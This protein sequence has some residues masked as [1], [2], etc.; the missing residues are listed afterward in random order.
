[1][2]KL[3]CTCG[4]TIRDNTNGLS[5]KGSILSDLSGEALSDW[6]V[7]EV[8]SYVEAVERGTTEAWLL[9]RGYTKEYVA[10]R[11]DHGNVMHDHLTGQ[12]RQVKRDIYECQT[13]GRVHLEGQFD[14]RFV[15]YQPDSGVVN[16]ILSKEPSGDA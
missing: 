6:L 1:M 9:D 4:N 8:Q 14:N 15:S 11:L 7:L 16:A 3:A 12:Y 5:Y 10:L 2:S 13:C